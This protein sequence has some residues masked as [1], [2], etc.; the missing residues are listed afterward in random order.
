MPFISKKYHRRH[1]VTLA[2]RRMPSPHTDENIRDLVDQVLDE[3]YIHPSKVLATL[4]D[5]MLT[6]FRPKTS[7]TDDDDNGDDSSVEEDEPPAGVR[8]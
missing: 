8:L 5:N 6:A 2:V 4:T 1:C 7:D 3:W